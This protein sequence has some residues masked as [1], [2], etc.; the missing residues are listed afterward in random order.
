MEK[1]L[2]LR[3]RI[4]L[5]IIFLYITYVIFPPISLFFPIPPYLPPILTIGTVLLLYPTSLFK[6]STICASIYLS[7]YFIYKIFGKEVPINGLGTSESLYYV[8]IE[9]SWVLPSVLIANVLLS[10]NNIVLYRKV[11]TTSLV[12]LLTSFAYL[13]PLLL[14]N[15]NILRDSEG[16]TG[17]PTY[18]L[19]HFYVLMVFPILLMIKKNVG[20]RRYLLIATLL[21]FLYVI[22][23]TSITTSL[24]V[25]LIIFL[26]VIVYTP[27][28]LRRSLITIFL[29][30]I[31][32]VIFHYQG[33]Y[34]DLCE[35]LIPFFEDTAVYDKLVDIHASLIGNTI[36]GDTIVGRM[37]LHQMSRDAFYRNP[38][39]G[40]DVVGGHSKLLDVLG[41]MGL[42]GFIPYITFIL[43][44]LRGYLTSLKGNEHSVYIWVS[45]ALVL[46]YLYIKGVF[47]APG[48]LFMFVII[49][50]YIISMSTKDDA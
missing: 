27:N 37:D 16:I 25:L 30:T 21:L 34:I 45:F 9:I 20:I 18:D 6:G 8:F 1:K 12:L 22:V 29:F 38:F 28:K 50:S 13:L 43:L 32:G 33:V 14:K 5:G 49:P 4:L 47:G 3:E 44:I 41:A 31:I 17:L 2:L 46:I 24:L 23:L 19:M 26:F 35:W 42:L 7:L 36:T 48:Y 39:I 40:S 15:S 10:L 11:R